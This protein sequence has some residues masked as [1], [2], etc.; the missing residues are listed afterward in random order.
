MEHDAKKFNR[1]TYDNYDNYAK[2]MVKELLEDRG[3]TILTDTEDYG[4]D[5]VTL[6]G[7]KVYY[8]EV[9][10]KVGYSFYGKGD[11]PFAS[12]SFLARKLRLHKKQPFYYI[13]ICKETGAIVYCHSSK[14]FKND[15]KQTLT[16]N[17]S[18]RQG[19]DTMYRVPVEEC[20]FYFD[21]TV[22]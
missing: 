16:V 20:G 17:S 19:L 14:I 12:V 18:E 15:Y 8:F 4:H 2:V 22:I 6:R 5:L 11:Y 3:H 7:D 9:E 13:I 10:V 21:K 1:H